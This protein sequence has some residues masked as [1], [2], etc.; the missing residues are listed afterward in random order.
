M[1]W[2]FFIPFVGVTFLFACKKDDIPYVAE[3]A[4]G[5]AV[6]SSINI[7][8]TGAAEI[9]AYDPDTKKLFV[10]TNTVTTQID[11]LDLTN[12]IAPALIGN[13]A[14]APF[15]GAVNSVAVYNG[16][17]AAAIEGYV[18]TDPGKVVVFNTSDY[19]V[20]KQIQVGAQPDMVAFSANG[21]YI[22]TANEGEPNDAYTID[23]VGSVS[24]ISVQNNYAVSSLDFSSFAARSAEL[25]ANGLRVFGP[26]ADFAQD[27]EPEYITISGDSKTAWVT[28]QENNAIARIDIP[29]KKITELFPLG[30][31]DYNVKDNEI[32]PSDKDGSVVFKNWNVKGMYQPDAI[33]VYE[34]KGIPFLFTANEGDAREWGSYT[35]GQRVK[36]LNLNAAS[37][38]NAALLKEDAQLGRLNVTTTLGDA[39]N[40]GT[41]ETLYSFGARSFSIW[42]GNTGIQIYDSKNELEQKCK[43]AGYYDDNRSDD[44]GVEPEGVTLGMVGRKLIA[45][46]GLERADALAL[47]DVTDPY[48]PAFIK[49]LPTG[50][51]PEGITFIPAKQNTLGKSLVVVSSENDGMI[52]IYKAS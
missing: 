18:K 51:A 14:I 39:G 49:L 8:K 20:I 28:L 35:E 11:I 44:K 30:F 6:I 23:P 48:H 2:R 29:S 52:K 36:S 40:D 17:L 41:Y 21:A 19:A 45:F 4:S 32:D 50:D 12:P 47:Y 7:G 15:G 26:G 22:L 5:F 33:A 1:K 13:I 27:M 42:N 37:F 10:V 31:K 34:H 46:V 3:D 24:I 25:Q 16:K 43:A 38:P 9:T